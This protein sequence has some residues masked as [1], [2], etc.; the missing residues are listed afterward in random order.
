MTTPAMIEFLHQAGPVPLAA[1]RDLEAVVRTVRVR[2]G[3]TLVVAGSVATDLGFV[4]TGLFKL[5]GQDRHG[6]AFVVEFAGPGSIVSDYASMIRGVPA[7]L[8]IEALEDGVISVFP[9]REYERLIATHPALHVVA[10]RV[11][12]DLVVKLAER[13]MQFLTLPA[14]DRY[15]EFVARRPDV[16]G[17][18]SRS[19]LA[20]YLGITPVSLSRLRAHL[21]QERRIKG[22][23]VILTPD[24]RALERL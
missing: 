14:R 3:W 10:R 4:D 18:I 5:H 16:L 6:K 19:D 13:E 20:A 15:L 12:E 24:A 23:K 11:L 2:R 7:G 9:F 1:L 8:T 21:R 17:R 22:S